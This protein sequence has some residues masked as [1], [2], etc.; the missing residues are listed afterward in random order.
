MDIVKALFDKGVDEALLDHSK[1]KAIVRVRYPKTVNRQIENLDGG[2]VPSW[3]FDVIFE[4]KGG[5][6][7]YEIKGDGCIRDQRGNRWGY[8]LTDV[9]L[10]RYCKVPPGGKEVI[11]NRFN[12]S[13]HDFCNGYYEM[14]YRGKDVEG[15]DILKDISIRL[16][17]SGC[18]GW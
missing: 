16:K 4:E 13:N 3:T 1:Q 18:G 2:S 17:H 12:D 8:G 5:R 11:S 7:G 6:I 10:R 9:A 15:N 14:T